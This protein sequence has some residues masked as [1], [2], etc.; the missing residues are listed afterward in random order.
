MAATNRFNTGKGFEGMVETILL[1]Y[2]C[3]GLL[4]V[5]K[6]DPPTRVVGSGAFR[7]VIF[8]ANPF[9]DFAGTW[10]ERG[11]RAVFFECK[12]TTE[13]R[14]AVGSSSGVTQDQC[15]ALC[16]WQNAGAVTFVLWEVKPLGKVFFAT[17][18]MLAAALEKSGR[19]SITPADCEPVP[20]G[21]GHVFFDFLKLMHKHWPT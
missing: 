16:H 14:L 5:K 18:V 7:K 19:K 17:P 13:Q 10:T 9:L 3:R 12:S 1:Q 6:V 2:Q 11:G 21:V 8:L 15:D 20:Q 4:R